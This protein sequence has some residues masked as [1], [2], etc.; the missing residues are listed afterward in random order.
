MDPPAPDDPDD[1]DVC[2]GELEDDP[3]AWRVGQDR[4]DRQILRDPD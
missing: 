3:E 4:Y 1:V 2:V